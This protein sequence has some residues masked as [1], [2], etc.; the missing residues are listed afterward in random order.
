[1]QQE[2][3]A[4]FGYASL[5]FAPQLSVTDWKNSSIS[6]SISIVKPQSLAS[7]G[8]D[9]EWQFQDRQHEGW[10]HLHPQC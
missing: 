8:V 5:N 4:A 6:P 1:M 3:K 2:N 9:G 7:H 10:I